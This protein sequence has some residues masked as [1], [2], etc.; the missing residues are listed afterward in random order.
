MSIAINLDKAKAIAHDVRRAARAAEFAPLDDQIVKQIPGTDVA[1]VEAQR[2][3]VR[4]KH[5]VMQTEMDA[6]E[7]PD[8]LKELLPQV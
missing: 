5:A 7:T 2:Q 1:A 4:D 8:E 6:A 3:A